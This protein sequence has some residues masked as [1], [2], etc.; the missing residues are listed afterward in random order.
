MFMPINFR[1]LPIG[2]LKKNS[3]QKFDEADTFIWIMKTLISPA[4]QMLYLSS[5]LWACSAISLYGQSVLSK[6]THTEG[7][8][9][10]TDDI[11]IPKIAQGYTAWYPQSRIPDGLIVFFH[12]RMDTTE[13]EP[14]ID[15]AM[16]AGIAIVFLNTSNPVEFL[17][18]E[19]SK[20]FLL[21]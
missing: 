20:D 4:L 17:F 5:I 8:V 6:Y 7:Q 14:I 1:D 15:Y 13:T 2:L 18:S 12:S 10:L 21:T 19:K 16:E 11:Q 3:I 9:V